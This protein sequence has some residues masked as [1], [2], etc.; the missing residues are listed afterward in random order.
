VTERR[1]AQRAQ[2]EAIAARQAFVQEVRDLLPGHFV[3]G[4]TELVAGPNQSLILRGPQ[5]Q[6]MAIFND[7]GLG[8]FL[9]DAF[10][11]LDAFSADIDLL[12]QEAKDGRRATWLMHGVLER[13]EA[14]ERAGWGTPE[15]ARCAREALTIY[16]N[17]EKQED[18]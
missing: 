8:R 4:E 5:G 6:N 2:A 15:G 14:A 3:S 10:D 13:L 9:M 7:R 1:A 11:N 12:Q 17:R 16:R 18:F